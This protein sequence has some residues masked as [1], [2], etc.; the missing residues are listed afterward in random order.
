MSFD[1]LNANMDLGEGYKD[2][3][4]N[5]TVTQ[6]VDPLNLDRI[7]ASVPGLY[8]PNQGAIP[9]IMPAK[10]SPF[11]IGST[12]GVYGS[13]AIGSDVLIW[14]QKGDP[15]FPLYMSMQVT[16][17]DEF[18]S[19]KSWGFVDP[20]GNTLN[21]QD[22]V[23]DFKSAS[24]VVIHI[25]DA[26]KLTITTAS[27]CDMNISGS[28]NMTIDGDWNVSASATTITSPTTIEGDFTVKGKTTLQNTQLNGTLMN[29]S[30]DLTT[31]RHGGVRSG[32]ETS[33]GPQ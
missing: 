8:D 27:D 3:Y 19:G 21:V 23:I 29:N 22:K 2:Q 26:G 6:N 12:W 25:D 13:P 32:G 10:F 1:N 5:G 20:A 31:H 28:M 9:W 4:F 16:A 30:I 15:H 11:G 33:A 24:G 17:N 14:L 18:P 7:Q